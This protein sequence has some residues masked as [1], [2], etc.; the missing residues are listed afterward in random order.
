VPG[1]LIFVCWW[2]ARMGRC[3]DSDGQP[4]TAFRKRL[5]DAEPVTPGILGNQVLCSAILRAEHRNK[6]S[7]PKC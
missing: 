3:R 4:A 6:S 5:L 1:E 2:W 7:M